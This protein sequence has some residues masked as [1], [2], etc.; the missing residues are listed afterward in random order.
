MTDQ[1]LTATERAEKAARDLTNA[2]NDIGFELQTFASAVMDEHRT[3]QQSTFGAFLALVKAWAALPDGR[4]DLRNEWT[5]QKSR[6]IVELIG[7]YN[8]KPPFI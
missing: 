7:E 8:L 2:V 4:Y 1:E 5:V 3:L 6:E